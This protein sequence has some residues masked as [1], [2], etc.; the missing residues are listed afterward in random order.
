MSLRDH[1]GHGQNLVA[2]VVHAHLR[3]PA[4][5]AHPHLALSSDHLGLGRQYHFGSL[6]HLPSVRVQLEY[7]H[8]RRCMRQSQCSLC[9]GGCGK[10]DHRYHGPRGTVAE[11]LEFDDAAGK[12]DRAVVDLLSGNVVCNILSS[13]SS[14]SSSSFIH[15]TKSLIL[16]FQ[17]FRNQY[18]PDDQLERYQF[19][20]HH[21]FVGKAVAVEYR[22]NPAG[23]CRREPA[24]AAPDDGADPA[25]HS[26]GD[27][28]EHGG[29]WHW[30][31]THDDCQK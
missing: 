30:T 17:R 16:G 2:V 6:P 7:E 21:L 24:L 12:E 13:S 25:L 20:G 14:T 11:Y 28:K 31:C 5:G 1:L 18:H 22:G 3:I 4:M 8:S 9:V 10:H 15:L 29:E 23:H 27:V 26:D 19:Q